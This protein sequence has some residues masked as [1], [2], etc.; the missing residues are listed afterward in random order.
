VLGNYASEGQNAVIVTQLQL[1]FRDQV[2]SGSQQLS[3][4]GFVGTDPSRHNAASS[5]ILAR[6]FDAGRTVQTLPEGT[7]AP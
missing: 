4:S 3:P 7:L 1:G 5:F 2:I 6:G